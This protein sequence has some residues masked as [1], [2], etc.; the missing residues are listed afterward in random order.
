M[1]YAP[2]KTLEIMS[3]ILTDQ[4]VTSIKAWCWVLG[5]LAVAILSVIIFCHV[6]YWL[7]WIGAA[8]VLIIIIA[9]F[10]MGAKV[11]NRVKQDLDSYNSGD[12]IQRQ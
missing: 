8:T 12:K 9:L 4:Q 3:N 10:V 6:V 7:M 5:I 1:S 11:A 2:H